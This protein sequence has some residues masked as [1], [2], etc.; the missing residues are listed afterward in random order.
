[1]QH[2]VAVAGEHWEGG[3][4]GGGA[5]EGS[6][7]NLSLYAA[8]RAGD[9]LA[10]LRWLGAKAGQHPVLTRSLAAALLHTHSGSPASSQGATTSW[11]AAGVGAAAG[12]VPFA[13]WALRVHSL[14]PENLQKALE[15]VLH[16]LLV[17]YEFKAQF[18]CAYSELYLELLERRLTEEFANDAREKRRDVFVFSVQLFTVPS[19]A[20]A[21][22]T[23]NRYGQL[24][25]LRR[26]LQHTTS[27]GCVSSLNAAGLLDGMLQWL[28]H[29]F[30][31][32]SPAR[33]GV[34]PRDLVTSDDEPVP[35]LD[36]CGAS[37]LVR[38]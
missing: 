9:C 21:L 18:A 24:R 2:D 32:S 27:P 38:V 1:M 17:V 22:V 4:G 31:N 30:T 3:G 13:A 23:D 19:L 28:L 33:G 14:L 6:G 10:L 8:A 5:A 12:G 34:R 29:H 16:N 7:G 37:S 26:A 20:R 15:D 25:R 36:E 11:Q 35:A